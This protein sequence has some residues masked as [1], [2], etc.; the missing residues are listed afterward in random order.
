ML[1]MVHN[2]KVVSIKE[3][4]AD[5][6]KLILYTSNTD[7]R[8][9]RIEVK[10]KGFISQQNLEFAVDRVYNN[11]IRAREWDNLKTESEQYCSNIIS[12]ELK[13]Y[14]PSVDG[15]LGQLTMQMSVGIEDKEIE[16]ITDKYALLDEEHLYN[17]GG[18][19]I[20]C[21]DGSLVCALWGIRE[22]NRTEKMGIQDNYKPSGVAFNTNPFGKNT[23]ISKLRLEN[24]DARQEN[25][26]FAQGVIY[27]INQ[28]LKHI[29][30]VNDKNAIG[31]VHLATIEGLMK[32]MSKRY[33]MKFTT[34]QS[35][36]TV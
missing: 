1:K 10:V 16:K 31:V 6:D 19:Y 24:T 20:V 35:N 14:Y 5:E 4:R 32:A 15:L 36:V 30:K 27:S 2:G 18:S 26:E 33:K 17:V 23:K 3:L 28:E 9:G 11:L 22:T 21:E 13:Q 29:Y 25:R 8:K 34:S 12:N 7:R